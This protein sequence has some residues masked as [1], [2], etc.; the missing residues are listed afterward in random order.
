MLRTDTY[1]LHCEYCSAGC[2]SLLDRSR[3]CN[4]SF[5]ETERKISFKPRDES[6]SSSVYAFLYGGY[7]RSQYYWEVVIMVERFFEFNLVTMTSLPPLTQGLVVL[8]MLLIFKNA[9][10]VYQPFSNDI[11]NRIESLSLMLAI[12]VL[13]LGFFLFEDGFQMAITVIMVTLIL[14]SLL[15]FTTVLI[16]RV[17]Q[18]GAVSSGQN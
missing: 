3:G 8:M 12:S 13:L 15:A 9:H 11:L 7:K 17:R 6:Y 16:M 18:S 4:I 2:S 10:S 5:K 1:R 14:I